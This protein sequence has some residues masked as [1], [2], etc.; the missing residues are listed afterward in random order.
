MLKE[1]PERIMGHL[2]QQTLAL[3]QQNTQN[4]EKSCLPLSVGGDLTIKGLKNGCNNDSVL[5]CCNYQ[6]AQPFHCLHRRLIFLEEKKLCLEE[7]SNTCLEEPSNTWPTAADWRWR[8]FDDR[9]G[10]G[11]HI[12]SSAKDDTLSSATGDT[13]STLKPVRSTS[14]AAAG[15]IPALPV[16]P[17]GQTLHWLDYHNHF[18]K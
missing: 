11:D 18:L 13:H 8:Q 15:T 14:S 4:M 7:P 10:R 5:N 16:L 17:Y 1:G 3:I 6:C 9:L 12:L 2:V